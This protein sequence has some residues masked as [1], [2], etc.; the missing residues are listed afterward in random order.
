MKHLTG[1]AKLSHCRRKIVHSVDLMTLGA[2]KALVDAGEGPDLR[3]DQ[4]IGTKLLGGRRP[5]LPWTSTIESAL[6][7]FTTFGLEPGDVLS[8]VCRHHAEIKGERFVNRLPRAII[9]IGLGHLID[10]AEL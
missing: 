5:M 3:L 8:E 2:L 7:L 4:E 1:P 10:H 6:T 9:S